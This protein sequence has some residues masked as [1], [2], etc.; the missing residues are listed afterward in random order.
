[1]FNILGLK[2]EFEVD[3]LELDALEL[4]TLGLAAS[5]LD[6]ALHSVAASLDMV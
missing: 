5:R 4:V 3:A 1:M 6:V 2:D